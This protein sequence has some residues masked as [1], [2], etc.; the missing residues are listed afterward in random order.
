MVLCALGAGVKVNV[1]VFGVL[2]G[3]MELRSQNRKSM[4][5]QS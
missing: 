5:L 4:E 2:A 3:K 1:G